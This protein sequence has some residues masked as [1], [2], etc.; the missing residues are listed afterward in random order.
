LDQ[1][2]VCVLLATSGGDIRFPARLL[3]GERAIRTSANS[4]YSDF[5]QAIDLLAGGAVKVDPLITHRFALADA[6]QAFAVAAD[7]AGAGAVKVIIRCD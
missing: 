1:A 5:P 6:E 7:K 3:T 4:L 2:G